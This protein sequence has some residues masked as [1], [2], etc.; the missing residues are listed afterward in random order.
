MN[1][2]TVLNKIREAL[3]MEVKLETME[4]A[5]GTVI[6]A[7]S[8]EAGAEV[9]ILSGENKV[10]LPIG[11]YKLM[12]GNVLIVVE[13]GIIAEMKPAEAPEEE[14]TPE[15]EMEAAKP[16]LEEETTPKKIVESISKEL[17]FSEIKKLQDEI[18]LL[19]TP[20][21]EVKEE[22]SEQKKDE[23]KEEKVKHSPEAHV[24]KKADFYTPK[25]NLSAKNKIYNKLFK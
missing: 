2:K 13:E 12:D 4:L 24:E 6:E 9:F 1:A 5:D 25:R 15:P 23:A 3:S 21:E 16:E 20:K 11:E 7:D 8:F 22:L 14:A 17:F 19:K 18:D 10:A